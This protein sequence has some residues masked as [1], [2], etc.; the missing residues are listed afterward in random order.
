MN[1]RR[2]GKRHNG[3][4]FCAKAQEGGVKPMEG[5][6]V[7]AGRIRCGN[8]LVT[9]RGDVCLKLEYL[10]GAPKSIVSLETVRAADLGNGDIHELP[11]DELVVSGP[12]AFD[13]YRMRKE[14]ARLTE[15]LAMPMKGKE[16]VTLWRR[17]RS[18]EI[19][20]EGDELLLDDCS[21]GVVTWHVVGL[22]CNHGFSAIRRKV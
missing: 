18:G 13:L 5:K 4:E 8:I 19:I 12:K 20:V 3:Y 17:V 15:P 11:H 14:V 7:Q 6:T 21:W 16:P 22:P 9:E 1:V 2:K 10:I